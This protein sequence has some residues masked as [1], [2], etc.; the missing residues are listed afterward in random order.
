M[1]AGAGAARC[2]WR[3]FGRCPIL[4]RN[5]ISN[6]DAAHRPG[7]GE[8]GEINPKLACQPSAPVARPNDAELASAPRPSDRRRAQAG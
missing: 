4:G 8:R 7:A 1:I 2:F 3:R 5:N 6:D